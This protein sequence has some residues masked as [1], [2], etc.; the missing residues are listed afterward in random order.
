[1]ELVGFDS[2]PATV[3]AVV[4]SLLA[5][6]HLTASVTPPTWLCGQGDR[7]NP[8]ELLPCL[9]GNLHV[10]T[11]RMLPPTPALFNIN[12]LDYD[13]DANAEPPERWIKFMEQLWGEDLE[14]MQLLQEWMGYCL[15]ADTRQQKMGRW[16]DPQDHPRLQRA[17]C[18]TRSNRTR[19]EKM[20]A[21]AMTCNAKRNIP[22][23]IHG[24]SLQIFAA[25]GA[26]IA[27][28]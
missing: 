23:R 16:V 22:P 15:V 19:T 17:L 4:L 25:E 21:S 12:A 14:S 24:S 6:V 8:N 3:N 1:M 28:Q 5:H 11:G 27:S 26:G 20:V 7:P 2:N 18:K 10:P 9:S 13:Y